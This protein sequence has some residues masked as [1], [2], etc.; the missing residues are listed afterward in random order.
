MKNRWISTR[1]TY[2]SKSRTIE[3]NKQNALLFLNQC[4]KRYEVFKLTGK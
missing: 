1:K 4:E 2:V 3:E